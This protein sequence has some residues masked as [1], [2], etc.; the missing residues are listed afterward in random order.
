MPAFVI[1][2]LIQRIRIVML[3]GNFNRGINE[4]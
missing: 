3:L 4:T 2:I 1:G